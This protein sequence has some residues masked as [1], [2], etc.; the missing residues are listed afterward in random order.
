MDQ[1]ARTVDSDAL[2]AKRHRRHVAGD[3]D[4]CRFEFCDVAR[5]RFLRLSHWSAPE[6]GSEPFVIATVAVP[7]ELLTRLLDPQDD[8]PRV[9]VAG[10]PADVADAALRLAGD[11]LRGQLDAIDH[12]AATVCAALAE[13]IAKEA[14]E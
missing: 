3:H 11:L 10:R 2:R 7:D 1:R 8:D 4:L 9:I 5:E 13:I 6:A 14:Q 12:R